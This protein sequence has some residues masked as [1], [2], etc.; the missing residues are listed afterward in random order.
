MLKYIVKRLLVMLLVLWAVSTMTYF[1]VHVTPG[2]AATAIVFNLTGGTNMDEELIERIN[3]R[4]DLDKPVYVQ[5]FNW[6]LGVFRMDFGISYRYNM[7]VMDMI[8][9]RLPNTVRLGLTAVFLS[10]LIGI[11]LG[12]LSA[13]RQN[14]LLDH[15]SR[16][17]TLFIGSI[18][19]FL[20]G[21]VL[22]IIFSLKL[23]W[24]P[25]SGMKTAGS[26]VLPAVTLALGMVATTTRMMR[27]GMLDV[28][29]QDFM[30]V[31]KAKGIRRSSML[32]SH[33]FRNA[34]PSIVTV[35]GLQIGHILGGSVLVETIFAW[36]GLGSLLNDA[37][38]SRDTPMLE[39][40]VILI[41]FGYTAINLLVD[42]VYAWLDPRVKY[43]EG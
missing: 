11:P 35:I 27:T 1:M 32:V 40:C 12:V 29:R 30:V 22:I 19:G 9:A 10:A 17:A 3:K 14:R 43:T 36:P 39:G 34:L 2:D 38:S 6:L 21:L 25:T 41:T 28:L 37:V 4:F 16:V 33:A 24:F 31:A 42:V 5:Y 23:K 18:P 15:T 26:I 8:K 20:S 7:P 13:L